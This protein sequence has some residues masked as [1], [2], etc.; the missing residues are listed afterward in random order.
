MAIHRHLKYIQN[1]IQRKFSH[2]SIN[3]AAATTSQ[4][5]K[6]FRPLSLSIDKE[7][8]EFQEN[9]AYNKGLHEKIAGATQLA[10]AGGG[11]KAIERHVQRKKGL[12]MDRIRSMLDEGEDF[13]EL[14]KLCG[15]KM[16]Y[17]DIPRAGVVT[18]MFLYYQII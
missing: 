7:S 1:I 18:G 5:R 16:E 15:L 2:S 4:P 6:V 14:S 9:S 13:F 8:K 12:V 17:G 3:A 11:P 10:E